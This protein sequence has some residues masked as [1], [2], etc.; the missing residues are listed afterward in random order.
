MNKD[1]ELIKITQTNT[2]CS[3]QNFHGV[4]KKYSLICRFYK[5]VIPK[6]FEKQVVERYYN[7]LCHP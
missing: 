1:K 2:D 4:D 7:V 6:Q 5:I 3:M